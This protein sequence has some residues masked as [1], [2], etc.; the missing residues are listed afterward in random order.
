M[1]EIRIKRGDYYYTSWGYDQTNIDYCV[2]VSVSPTGKTCLCKMVAPIYVGEQGQEDVLMPGTPTGKPFRMRIE[3]NR[4]L[5]GSYPFCMG[6][7][8]LDTFL[9]T[10]LGETHNQTN[11]MFGH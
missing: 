2:V 7:T 3:D 1:I 5:R 11:P 6:S 8:R 9:P 10:T 4:T